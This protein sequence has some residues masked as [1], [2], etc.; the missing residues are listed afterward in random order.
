M[1]TH[2]YSKVREKYDNYVLI[3]AIGHVVILGIYT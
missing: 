3:S 2:M 1:D